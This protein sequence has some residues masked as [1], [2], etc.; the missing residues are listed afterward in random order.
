ML[1][2]PSLSP[3]HR[4]LLLPHGYGSFLCRWVIKVEMY[5]HGQ[6][7]PRGHLQQA[8][9]LLGTEVVLARVVP[10][11]SPSPSH[12][13]VI[14]F[15]YCGSCLH[16]G[17]FQASQ[18]RSDPVDGNSRWDCAILAGQ[19]DCSSINGACRFCGRSCVC[20]CRCEI[21]FCVISDMNIWRLQLDY[22]SEKRDKE[23]DQC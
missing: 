23:S 3:S 9:L 1:R 13:Q 7:C 16:L 20:C 4:P 15:E 22:E 11:P 19:L 8:S 6:T 14:N 10:Y 12:R 17:V 5:D 2:Y 18:Q 21:I